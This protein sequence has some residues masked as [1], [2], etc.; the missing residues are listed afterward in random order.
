MR[1]PDGCNL[2]QGIVTN[3]AKR[4]VTFHFAEPDPE[5]L[6][7]LT[8]FA[9]SAPVPPGTPDREPGQRTVPGTGPYK[10][11][12]NRP[13]E[14]RFVRNPY[15]REWSHAAQ[16]AGNPN[17]IVWQ[18]A[19]SLQAAVTAVEQ[20][21]ADWLEGQPPYAQYHQLELQD[22][23]QLHNNPQWAVAFL[24]I[25]T[26]IPPF[27]DLGVRQALSYAI[28]RAKLAQLYGGD[29][30]LPGDR[31][32]NTRLPPLLPLHAAPTRQRRLERA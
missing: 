27:N 8:E 28:N 5:F 2:S 26:H 1:D 4:T 10:I 17:E 21:R 32:R 12:S 6:Y 14:I 29:P 30:I 19:P 11:V 25:N 7:Q 15:F 3:D 9:F 22:P 16:P 24:P 31:A 13:A 20:G 18:S 23:G